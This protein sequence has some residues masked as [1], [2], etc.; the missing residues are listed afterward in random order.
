MEISVVRQVLDVNDTMSEENRQYFTQQG[1]YVFNLMSSPGS[2][3]TTLLTKILMRLKPEIR[4]AVIV[5]DVCTTN[6]ADRLAVTGVP[7]VQITTDD[8][9]GDCHLAA[10]VIR[11]AAKELDLTDIDLLIVE[12]IGNL[13]CPAEFSIGE[14]S[15][16]VVLSITEGEDKPLK[17]PLMFRVCDVAILNKMDLVPYLDAD[18]DLAVKNMLTVHPEMPVF[19]TSAT[20]ETGLDEF[21]DWLKAQMAK[22]AQ[23]AK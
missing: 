8:F 17:Y 5:G 11:K 20:K 3:K 2:G 9:G 21:I 16:G 14:D 4:A 15:K 22:K 13:V 12:N 19:K 23:A 18:P 7:V 6:D 10:H 1:V